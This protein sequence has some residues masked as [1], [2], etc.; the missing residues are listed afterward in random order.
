METINKI[1]LLRNLLAKVISRL[2]NHTNHQY[3]LKKSISE[4]NF[5]VEITYNKKIIFSETTNTK[6]IDES[7]EALEFFVLKLIREDL[8]Y[9]AHI[10]KDSEIKSIV[11]VW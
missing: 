11:G 9:R 1:N 5:S 7:Y 4:S 3:L 10:T 8:I 2:N 6:S